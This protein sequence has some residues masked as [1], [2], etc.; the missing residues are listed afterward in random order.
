MFPVLP[1]RHLM[2]QL[3]ALRHLFHVLLRIFHLDLPRHYLFDMP[4]LKHCVFA[5]SGQELAV[6][7]ELSDP[8][9]IGVRAYVLHQEQIELM[10]IVFL[11]RLRGIVHVQ[12]LL[13]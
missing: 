8:Y 12:P 10:H 11:V 3:I 5:A 6:G 7:T 13:L 2:E 9:D 1:E 4:N